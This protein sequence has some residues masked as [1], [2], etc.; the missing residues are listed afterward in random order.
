MLC[1]SNSYDKCYFL[2]GLS[3]QN[4]VSVIRELVDGSDECIVERLR[5]LAISRGGLVNDEMRRKAWP[6]L[7]SV[8]ID[9]IPQT[10][11]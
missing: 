1:L 8:D 5:Q 9:N 3:E 7:L 11:G 2:D 4:K 10:P 6:K